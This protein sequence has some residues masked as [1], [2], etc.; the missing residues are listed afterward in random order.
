MLLPVVSQHNK[1]SLADRT[2]LWIMSHPSIIHY[3]LLFDIFKLQ[4]GIPP[5][6]PAP[7]FI[8]IK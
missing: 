3:Y 1:V 2:H 6:L 5:A 7:F 4:F 8:G